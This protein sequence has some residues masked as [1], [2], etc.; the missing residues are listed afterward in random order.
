M[1]T[2]SKA[3]KIR[4]YDQVLD[5]AVRFTEAIFIAEGGRSLSP[6][7][8]AIRGWNAAI[9]LEDAYLEAKREQHEQV[10]RGN[11]DEP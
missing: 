8:V 9:Q 2:D 4:A 11:T 3:P 7:Q 10:A 5:H 6:E 1:S